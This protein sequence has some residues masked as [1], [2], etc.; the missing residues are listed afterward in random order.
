MEMY[1]CR[2]CGSPLSNLERHV[3]VCPN[4]HTLFANAS[5]TVGIFLV[6]DDAHVLLAVRR[7]EPR[8]GCLDAFG[9]FLD[10]AEDFQTAAQ[11]EL[12]E[13]LS[14]QASEYG[15]LH[16]LTSQSAAYKY[17]GDTIPVV[18]VFY[19]ARLTTERSLKPAD[20][21]AAVALKEIQSLDLAVFD[22]ADDVKAGFI[23]LQ[24]LFR[25]DSPHVKE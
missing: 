16:Y 21:V 8:Q 4:R 11:R 14:L 18:T 10:G 9:G 7:I 1:F 22:G 12:T 2:R 6:T 13:E 17:Q 20:D 15:E 23:A 24:E 25:T 19:W 3:Y 5:P